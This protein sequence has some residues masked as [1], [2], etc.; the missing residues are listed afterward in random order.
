MTSLKGYLFIF[1]VLQLNVVDGTKQSLLNDESETKNDWIGQKCI[2]IFKIQNIASIICSYLVPDTIHEFCKYPIAPPYLTNTY[3]P[4][5][6]IISHHYLFARIDLDDQYFNETVI[7]LLRHGAW[8][9][10]FTKEFHELLEVAVTSFGDLRRQERDLRSLV[11]YR[12][13]QFYDLVIRKL[14]EEEFRT[15]HMNYQTLF[16]NLCH[17][18]TKHL[19]TS[20]RCP[21]A[22]AHHLFYVVN[23]PRNPWK[24]R[25]LFVTRPRQT[26]CNLNLEIV[27]EML[28]NLD[29]VL[30]VTM[31]RHHKCIEITKIIKRVYRWLNF[32]ISL[33]SNTCISF[34]VL[35]KFKRIVSALVLCFQYPHVAILSALL[36]ISNPDVAIR[37]CLACSLFDRV[38]P[39]LP[40]TF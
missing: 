30:S 11:Y 29:P 17:V 24:V 12:K 31:C 38:D 13:I 32:L 5:T 16:E 9:D 39:L 2:Q 7:P 27:R 18:I 6:Y 23:E 20:T 25:L 40:Y 36:M 1:I 28:I 3:F 37:V 10:T 15:S 35:M 21:N 26:N 19:R 8:I 34:V 22:S 33:V 14:A 4:Y